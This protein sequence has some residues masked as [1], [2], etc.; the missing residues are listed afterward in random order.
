MWKKKLTHI[1]EYFAREGEKPDPVFLYDVRPP[2]NLEF[3]DAVPA[4]NSLRVFYE[5]C[6]GGYFGP[7]IRF[8]P[9]GELE[10]ETQ[11]WLE[12]IRQERGDVIRAGQHSVFAN[13][14]DG[15]PWIYDDQTREV[16]V[17]YWKGG[18]WC[19][20]RFASFDDFMNDVFTA[21]PDDP[22]WT[23]TVELVDAW[24]T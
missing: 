7:M 10:A 3:P 1:V 2:T 12:I 11:Q 19:E 15:A 8:I 18:D 17:F 14:S 20:P 24:A 22:N 23:R 9:L 13:D 16:A 21:K 6:D 4:P 5:I